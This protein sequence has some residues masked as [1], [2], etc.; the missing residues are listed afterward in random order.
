MLCELPTASFHFGST[1]VLW[2]LTGT[3]PCGPP[4]RIM[5]VARAPA[6]CGLWSWCCCRVV[7]WSHRKVWEYECITTERT[8]NEQQKN[9]KKD[10]KQKRKKKRTTK[11]QKKTKKKNDQQKKEQKKSN[12]ST[13]QKKQINDQKKRTKKKRTKKG[14]KNSEQRTTNK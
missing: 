12:K 14:T 4:S 5:E 8:K 6:L 10:Q 13:K 11:D 2:V 3:Y 7:L 1:G 9:K